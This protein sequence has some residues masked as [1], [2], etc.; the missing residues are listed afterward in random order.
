MKRVQEIAARVSEKAEWTAADR[1]L[2]LKGIFDA[3]AAD[4]RRTAI[5]AI[6]EA[7]K[8]QGS[9]PPAQHRIA[10]PNGGPIQTVDLTNVSADDLE[11]LEALFGPLAGGSGDNDASDPSGEGEESS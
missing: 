4:D 6:A 7:N 10:G 9:Y 11:R 5:A 2:A 3:S 1:L 8:M